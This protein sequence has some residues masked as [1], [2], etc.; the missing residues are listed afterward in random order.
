MTPT[1][2]NLRLVNQSDTPGEL[3]FAIFQK[4]GAPGFEGPARPWLIFRKLGHGDSTAFDFTTE[5]KVAVSDTYGN[6]TPQMTAEPGQKF[7][8]IRSESGDELVQHGETNDPEV[9][10]VWN[11]LERG[12]IDAH[13]YRSG[14]RLYTQTN[15]IP[16]QK[17]SFQFDDTIHVENILA[18]EIDH[19][20]DFDQIM[21]EGAPIRLTGIA[22]ADI[23]VKGGGI[24]MSAQAY[25][26]HLENV[27]MKGA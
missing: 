25:S 6:Y 16:E 23:V 12:A 15:V 13:C 21:D 17:A 24:G 14:K 7:Q 8:M 11:M 20:E 9:M 18:V 27:V 10:D 5:L 26:Y 22:S 2:I 19:S 4:N 1:V 3:S